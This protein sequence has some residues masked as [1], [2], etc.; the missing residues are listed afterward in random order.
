MKY[1][2]LHCG[3]TNNDLKV[4]NW[5]D[6]SKYKGTV[7]GIVEMNKWGIK[8]LSNDV[9]NRSSPNGWVDTNFTPS[10]DTSGFGNHWENTTIGFGTGLSYRDN[11]SALGVWTDGAY[12]SVRLNRY[13][14]EQLNWRQELL[15]KSSAYHFTATNGNN[16]KTYGRNFAVAPNGLDIEVWAEG[17]FADKTAITAQSVNSVPT[18]SVTLL[19]VNEARTGWTNQVVGGFI[20]TLQYNYYG[21]FARNANFNKLSYRLLNKF[22]DSVGARKV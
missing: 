12:T 6:F 13:F 1:F 14:Y 18:A 4:T 16:P 8:I 19:G 17:V 22:V 20:G 9:A 21:T 5:K 15:I 2:Y 7:N 3:E 10:L 11:G